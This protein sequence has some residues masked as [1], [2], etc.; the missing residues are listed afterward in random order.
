MMNLLNSASSDDQ[1]ARWLG[2]LVGRL[3][4]LRACTADSDCL[5][6]AAAPS[7]PTLRVDGR[8]ADNDFKEKFAQLYVDAAAWSKDKTDLSREIATLQAQ[9][10]HLLKLKAGDPGWVIA[11]AGAQDSLPSVTWSDYWGGATA[12][13]RE[14][15]VPGL[16]SQKGKARIDSFFAEIDRALSDPAASAELK[17]RFERWYRAHA[18]EAWRQFIV[19]FHEGSQ[20]L[21]DQKAWEH[22]APRMP[23]DEGPYFALLE[24]VGQEFD[25]VDAGD[26]PEWL[27]HIQKVRR[28]KTSV[29]YWNYLQL[30]QKTAKAVA[31]SSQAAQSTAQ[32]F[33]AAT[34]GSSVFSDAFDALSRLKASVPADLRAD[35][36]T[37]SLV[38]GPLN[39][40]WE[41]A[42]R[43]TA[44]HLQS[45]WQDKV[46]SEATGLSG[47]QALPVLL[48]KEGP[49]MR[50][51]K[52][53]AVPYIQWSPRG[54]YCAK[55]AFGE[56][57]PFTREFFVFLNGAAWV[58]SVNELHVDITALDPQV[59]PGAARIPHIIQ[60]TLNS[61]GKNQ[62]LLNRR[63]RVFEKS[64]NEGH[65]MFSWTPACAD[66]QLDITV[67]S[68]HL[69]KTYPG[70]Y[71]FL[72][73]LHDFRSGKHT[74]LKSDFPD[75]ARALTDLKIQWIAPQ[76]KFQGA[77]DFSA[78]TSAPTRILGT[79][80]R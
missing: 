35:P 51:A 11:W 63:I 70:S 12:S 71:G 39:F 26:L 5:E 62:V 4:V 50:F 30:L 37:W 36:M 20:R 14:P 13:R 54:G 24:H 21:R 73:F 64:F 40:L 43:E 55:A 80:D 25:A 7:I 45:D 10:M 29:A 18:F 38:S 2:H 60:L 15:S 79:W 74:F 58:S 33:G 47:T 72:A 34:P 66:T 17:A 8:E 32:A 41:D 78:P 44:A 28:L 27:Q 57:L 16:F 49:V 76:Y 22:M 19:S 1:Y 23:A 42:R 48:S 59:N 77:P 46:L 68:A 69:R 53:Q 65:Q 52:E 75:S 3:T 61:G 56:T 9:L 6:T 31:D 67:G